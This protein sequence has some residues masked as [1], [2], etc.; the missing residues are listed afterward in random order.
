VAGAFGLEVRV[1]EDHVVFAPGDV[2]LLHEQPGTETGRPQP[3]IDQLDALVER[4]RAD[5][6]PVRLAFEGTRAAL[7]T[8]IDRAA[9]RIVE[10]AL[11]GALEQTG[12]AHARVTVRYARDMLQLEITDDRSAVRAAGDDNSLLAALRVRAGL[13]GGRLEAGRRSDGDYAVQAWLPLEPSP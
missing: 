7:P 2:G 12:P 10:E 1:A 6:R 3:G 4:A 11:R 5:G 13:Y 8:G 9:Y